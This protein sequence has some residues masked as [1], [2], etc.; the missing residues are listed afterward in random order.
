MYYD[1]KFHLKYSIWTIL[2]SVVISMMLATILEH[3]IINTVLITMVV[4]V[5]FFNTLFFKGLLR[6]FRFKFIIYILI[7]P[8]VA[9][10]GFI[11]LPFLI[12]FDLYILISNKNRYITMFKGNLEYAS[13]PISSQFDDKDLR[14]RIEVF[15]SR[16]NDSSMIMVS[17]LLLGIMAIVVSFHKYSLAIIVLSIL[18]EFILYIALVTS[19]GR[20]LKSQTEK[21]LDILLVD[22][23]GATI[24]RLFRLLVEKYNNNQFLIGSYI[25]F[26]SEQ[27]DWEEVSRLLTTYKKYSSTM[28][29]K[30]AY[31]KLSILNSDE[32]QIKVLLRDIDMELIRRIS[33]STSRKDYVLLKQEVSWLEA[34]DYQKKLEIAEEMNKTTSNA[35]EEI[36]SLYYLAK[37][38]DL[39]EDYVNAKVL[40]QRVI[41]DGNTLGVVHLAKQGINDI[42]KSQD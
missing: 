18:I 14:K 28:N 23:D 31:L 6:R 32:K 5:F 33:V 20:K 10:I 26:A 8:L 22:K 29:Y 11:S 13:P 24:Y 9:A 41:D 40:Y 37:S 15:Q 7:S 1:V 12:L 17:I 2:L 30:I 38:Y 42:E 35:F 3:P 39:L 21:F 25:L 16:M 34:N 4:F 36:E 27:Q 19:F